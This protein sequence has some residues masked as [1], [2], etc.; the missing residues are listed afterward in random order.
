MDTDPMPAPPAGVYSRRTFLRLA[1]A[2]SAVL[3]T[4]GLLAACGGSS[5]SSS[6]SAASSGSS[7]GPVGGP[8]N[9]FTW[10]GYDLTKPFKQWRAENNIQNVKY[11][12]NQFDVATILENR[13]RAVSSSTRAR[14]TRL[15]APVPEPQR[16]GAADHG[17]RCRRW[18]RCTPSSRTA[19]SGKWAAG[20]APG[21]P[22]PW[23][24]GAIGINYL[25]DNVSKPDSWNVLD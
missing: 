22:A 1:G 4:S 3:G 11:I 16:D 10:Q 14:P 6:G 23:T 20:S 8:F 7:V 25:T 9:L 21:R 15:H 18:A 12:N 19:R 13:P 2:G 24:W 5:A 17:G